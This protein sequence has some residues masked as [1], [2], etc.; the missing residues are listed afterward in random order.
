M[1][2]NTA[3]QAQYMNQL[4][5]AHALLEAILRKVGPVTLTAEEASRPSTGGRLRSEPGVDGSLTLSLDEER[6]SNVEGP[7]NV[8]GEQG[9]TGT[10][11][12]EGV[13]SQ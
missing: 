10:S 4:A 7:E 8:E 12:G 9:A 6:S 13:A 5:Q 11:D 3:I 2:V 1:K